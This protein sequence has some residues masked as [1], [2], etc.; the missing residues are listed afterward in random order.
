MMASIAW[1]L[2]RDDPTSKATEVDEYARQEYG[3]PN[4]AWLLSQDIAPE[5]MVEPDLEDGV[6]DSL[7]RRITQAIASFL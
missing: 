6:G 1:A 2:V 4:A 7:F 5:A 3:G